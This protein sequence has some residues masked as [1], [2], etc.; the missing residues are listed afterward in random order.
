MTL[1]I[2]LRCSNGLVMA[3]DSRVTGGPRKSADISEKFLQINRD[4]GIMT[5]GLAV[6]GYRGIRSLVEEVRQNPA[7]Y[8]TMESITTRAQSLFQETLQHFLEENRQ[9]DGSLPPAIE[10][11]SVGYIIGGYDGNDTAQF[12][13]YLAE[14]IQNFQ[15]N[16]PRGSNLMAAQWHLSEFLLP[17]LEYPGMS[18]RHG[19]KIAATLLTLTSTFEPTV[20]GPIHLATVTIEE[21]FTLLYERKVAS[22]IQE[23]QPLLLALKRAWL[24]AWLSESNHTT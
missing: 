20:G 10:H 1:A 12:R 4:V 2:A 13:V 7:N 3:S 6:P 11:Q 24:D 14:S 9:P 17:F 21:G 15:L 19:C 5:Y 22:I 18:V 16:E 8:P 23:I